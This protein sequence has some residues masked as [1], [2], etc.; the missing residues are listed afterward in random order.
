VGG[1]LRL[2]DLTRLNASFVASPHVTRTDRLRFLR[3]YMLWGLAGQGGW[4]D[5]WRTVAARTEDKVRRN[6]RRNRPLA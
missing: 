3:T 2:R 6:R 1:R 5:W 4:K